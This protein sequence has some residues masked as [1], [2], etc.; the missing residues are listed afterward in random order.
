MLSDEKGAVLALCSQCP[1]PEEIRHVTAGIREKWT[2]WE[3]ASRRIWKSRTV[4]D[5]KPI[6]VPR[7]V[8]L[9]LIAVLFNIHRPPPSP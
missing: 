6:Q 4:P 9:G 3:C 7:W 1:S 5:D 8:E 2:K